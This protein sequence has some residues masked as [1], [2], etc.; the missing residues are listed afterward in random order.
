M[1]ILTFGI[2]LALSEGPQRLVDQRLL[3][4]DKISSLDE[5]KRRLV[6]LK[7]FKDMLSPADANV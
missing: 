7:L 2:M 6:P 4:T 3:I 1:M 5:P